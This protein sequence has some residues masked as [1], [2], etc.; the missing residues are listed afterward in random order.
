MAGAHKSGGYL[1]F[2]WCKSHKNTPHPSWFGL[3]FNS[4]SL[5]VDLGSQPKVLSFIYY[6]HR[7]TLYFNNQAI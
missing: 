5:V 4:C 7:V 3:E 2:S 6:I 1:E